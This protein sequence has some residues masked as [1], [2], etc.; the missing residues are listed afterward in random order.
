MKTITVLTATR[1]EY[2]LLKPII[3]AL[4]QVKNLQIKVAVTG[5]HLS[6]EFGLT[7]K[8]IE[9]DGIKIDIKIDIL[10]GSGKPSDI[11]RTMAKAMCGFADYFENNRSDALIVLGD[12]YETL[13]VCLAAMNERIPIIHLYG[14]DKTEGAVDEAIRHAITKISLLHLVSTMEVRNRVIQLGEQPDRVLV[15]GAIGV[16]NVMNTP[17]MSLEDLEDS[18][19]MKLSGGYAVVT[20]HPVTLEKNS[21][22]KQCK[23]LLY[24]ISKFP[25]I[26]FIITK[27]NADTDGRVINKLLYEY[28]KNH[29]NAKLFDSLGMVRYLSAVK[30]SLVVIG[31][32]SS[33]LVEVPSFHVP[34]V[35]IGERQKGRI[36]P[37]S[38]IDC[39]PCADSI[40]RAI[41]KALSYE[42]KAIC[43][44]VKNP[45]GDGNTT[46]KIV[47]AVCDM[48]NNPID[49]KKHFYDITN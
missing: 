42:F 34:T 20:F 43:E 4:K 11:T 32:S 30:H 38:V 29:S 46:K 6:P 14:G 49:I 8:E 18:L 35:N 1:A 15:V 17:L 24:A 36:R 45:Y 12:R 9:S 21:A 37:E 19:G 28:V 48:L 40:V 3:V 2:G 25:E 39:E 5:A 33:G 27:A 47:S 23:E 44:R 16:E 26:N 10:K 22:E 41:N 7:Y 31:N 13:A